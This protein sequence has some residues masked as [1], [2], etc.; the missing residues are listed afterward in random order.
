MVII[1]R[2]TYSQTIML[3]TLNI[4]TA[5]SQLYLKK[6]GKHCLIPP[7]F[8]IMQTVERT[9]L[10]NWIPHAAAKDLT[11][12]KEDGRSWVRQLRPAKSDK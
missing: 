6:A 4:H 9:W 10:G 2:Y 12:H 1:P 3:Y 7:I 8:C 5:E 11:Y